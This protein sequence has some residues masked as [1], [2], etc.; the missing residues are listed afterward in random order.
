MN[1]R[2]FIKAIGYGGAAL[3]TGKAT[4]G[5]PLHLV[6]ATD[7]EQ[8]SRIEWIVYVTG[9]GDV[10]NRAQ[11]RCAVRVTS[12][13]GVQ[14]WADLSEE[15]APDRDAAQLV[16]GVLLGRS[17][18]EHGAVWRE[19]HEAGLSIVALAAV[20]IALWD[21]RGRIAGKAVHA[22]LGTQ[23]LEA[24][25]YLTTDFNLGDP[26][27]YAEL[28]LACRAKGLHGVKI[29]PYIEWGA[30]RNG[31]TDAGHPDRDTIVY[32][33]VRDAVGPDYPCM[34][35]NHATYTYDEARRVGK[36]LD[37]LD[38]AWY[39]S[40][41]PEGDEWRDRY[42]ALASEIKTPLCAPEANSGSFQSRA[43][44]VAAG[45]CDI[46][47]I[48]VR[49]GGFTACLEL[50]SVCEATGIRLELHNVGPD[51]YAHL[52]LVGAT[53]ESRVRYVELLSISRQSRT[54]P[55]R[56]TPEPAFD[57]QGHVAVPQTPGMGIELD[58]KYIQTHR[59]N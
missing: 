58:W 53:P 50:A 46:A 25:A 54:L 39:E 9:R 48:N 45:A 5:R 18:S 4:F 44:W 22:L 40:P 33:A 30:G 27:A 59:A 21:L 41:M 1:R 55:G 34:A 26:A 19:L 36:R 32:E 29:H 35:D 3:V 38:Y 42:V 56:A 16:E 6:G 23:R 57:E 47:R 14:G 15:A 43:S 52:Q 2:T 51:A 31:R 11:H 8:V 20:D 13:N 49:S 10:D 12:A 24:K 17:V 7:A 37:D 28:A